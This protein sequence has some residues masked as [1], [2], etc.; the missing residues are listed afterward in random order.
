M[1]HANRFLLSI[2]SLALLPGAISAPAPSATDP[3]LTAPQQQR[4]VDA[5]QAFREGRYAAAYGRFA[6]LADGCHVPSAQLALAMLRQG[7]KLFGSDWTASEPQQRRWSVM[8][9]NDARRQWLVAR[10]GVAD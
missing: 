9:V 3:G 2:A 4:W 5:Q 6:A 1:R 7:P 10:T 8:V